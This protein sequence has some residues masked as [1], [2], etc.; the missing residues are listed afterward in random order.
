MNPWQQANEDAGEAFA[1]RML[2]DLDIDHPAITYGVKLRAIC[3]RLPERLRW[4]PHNL[5][6]HPAMELIYLIT[7]NRG[8]GDWLHD[9]TIP[10]GEDVS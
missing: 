6:A 5:I 8:W 7:G 1:E 10:G 4:A 9:A 3:S 2:E